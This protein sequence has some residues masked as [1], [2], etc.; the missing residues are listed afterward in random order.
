MSVERAG[1]MTAKND[2]QIKPGEQAGERMMNNVNE[3]AGNENEPEIKIRGNVS[4]QRCVE[5]HQ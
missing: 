4:E 3:Q 5:K 1:G 2:R